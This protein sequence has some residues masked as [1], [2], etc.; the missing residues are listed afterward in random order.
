MSAADP[1][2]P[3]V[4]LVSGN[5]S[6]LQA[7]FDACAAGHLPARVCA[8]VSNEPAAY[9]LTRAHQANVPTAV[10]CHRDFR[11]RHAYDTALTK[12]V[13]GYQPSLVVLAGFM[14]ILTPPFVAHFWGRMLN[15]HP[16]LL[17]AFRGLHTHTRALAAGVTEHG[18]SVHFV[19]DDLD[20]GPVVVQARVP[21]LPGDTEDV[22]AARV[23]TQEHRI[24]PLAVRWFAQ[25]R[26]RLAEDS[27]AWLDDQ[28]LPPQGVLYTGEEVP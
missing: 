20:G 28:P 6:N 18:A 14:R 5:G 7:L 24:Y 25:G 16:A 23:L 21:V 1:R 8:V 13:D 3:M 22:L 27:R 17:P 11:G 15:I 9:A 4:V 19:T 12:L 2:F 26:L 10:L